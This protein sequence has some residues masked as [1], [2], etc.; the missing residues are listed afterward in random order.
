[1]SDDVTLWFDP[2]CPFTW[3]TSRWVREV[4]QKRNLV[5]GWQLLS[6]ATLNAEK[7]VPEQYRDAFARGWRASR[8]LVA[9]GQRFGDEAVDRLYTEIG[10]RTH[11]N[12]RELDTQVLEESL[13]AAGLPAD[14]IASADDP[15][16]D[17]A[18][19][20]SHAE[21]QARVGTESGSPILAIGDGP[22]FFGPVVVP[23]PEGESAEKLFDA[24]RLLS[25]VPEFSELKRSRNSF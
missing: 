22:G 10:T 3:R 19:A 13:E 5:V 14:L 6:L 8:L 1:M 2:I 9:A 15:A 20:D 12:G 11:D 18:I 23:V 16:L 25:A 17:Q 21:G 7:E 4:T 24:V